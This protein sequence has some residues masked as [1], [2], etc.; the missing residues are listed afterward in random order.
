ML[1]PKQ[2]TLVN[3]FIADHP[4]LEISWMDMFDGALEI[5]F[6]K[7]RCFTAWRVEEII[8]DEDDKKLFESLERKLIW[9]K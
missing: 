5:Y 9:R 8:M 7:D 3:K 6:D 1:N 2:K 4:H